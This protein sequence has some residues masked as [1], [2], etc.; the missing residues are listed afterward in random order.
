[1]TYYQKQII[2]S[3]YGRYNQL[4]RDPQESGNTSSQALATSSGKELLKMNK[5]I[6]QMSLSLHDILNPSKNE[7]DRLYEKFNGDFAQD[8]SE[9]Q[10]RN[11]KQLLMI[12]FMLLDLQNTNS[13]GTSLPLLKKGK[14]I[15]EQI[16]DLKKMFEN[17]NIYRLKKATWVEGQVLISP[18]VSEEQ[19][20]QDLVFS[21]NFYPDLQLKALMDFVDIN[22][23]SMINVLYQSLSKLY[24]RIAKESYAIN[25]LKEF[26]KME[27][28]NISDELA[29]KFY[30]TFTQS[31]RKNIEENEHR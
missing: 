25:Y 10:K 17:I 2:E 5:M 22:D 24:E 8:F 3:T 1:M 27:S 14:K 16:P 18:R 21:N 29:K 9:V 15:N 12:D 11:L 4:A 31:L 23:P 30:D 6:H 13:D 26:T 28:E 19:K 20:K 7:V